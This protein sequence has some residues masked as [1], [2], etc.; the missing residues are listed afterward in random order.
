MNL[1][2]GST[3]LLGRM[4]TLGLLE[5]G[6][7]VRS[8][9][10]G[11]ASI[12]GVESVRGDLKDPSSLEKAM[13]GI[14]TVITSATSAQRGGDDNVSSVDDAGNRSLIDAA[15]RAGV[16]RFIFISAA[17]V[18]E[19]S[20]VPLFAAKARVEKHLRDSGMEWTIVAPHAF[21]DVWFPLLIGSAIGSGQ[22]VSLIGGGKRRH[23][24]IAVEDV[25][26]FAVAAVGNPAARN[27]RIVIGGP[28]ALS[29]QDVVRQSSEILRREI[30]TRVIEPG[31]PIP[32]LPPPLNQVIG[33]LA[34]GLEQQDVIL[35]TQATARTFGITLTPAATVLRRMFAG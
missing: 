29:F 25:A 4:I 22:P 1:V 26:R 18:D 27:L 30:P 16:S 34:A 21:M 12:A 20:P 15:K 32:H 11:D 9:L 33:Q 14:T 10:R 17:A 3:G 35:D 24:F 6:L 5:R 8:L 23:S 13:H 2:V 7:P 28:E 19:A 31:E